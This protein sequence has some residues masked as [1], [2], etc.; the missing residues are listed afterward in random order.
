[1]QAG[2]GGARAAPGRLAKPPALTA[3]FR[4][5]TAPFDGVVTEKLVEPGNMATPGLPLVR[6]EDTRGFRLDVRVDESRVA[7]VRVGDTGVGRAPSTTAEPVTVTGTVGEVSR[8][9]DADARAFLREDRVA[10]DA[11]VRSGMFGRARFPGRRR[12]R[13]ARAGRRHRDVAG[14]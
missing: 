8:A 14:R 13:P 1:M 11:R 5:V 9:V 4:A 12:E 7:G 10:T 2:P 3:S 6:V